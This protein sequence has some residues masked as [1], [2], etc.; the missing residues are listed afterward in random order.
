MPKAV[1]NIELTNLPSVIDDL[2][3]YDGAFFLLRYHGKP[4]GKIILP[5]KN[6]RIVLAD[7]LEKIKAAVRKD[8]KKAVV[9]HFLFSDTEEKFQKNPR[10]TIAI[11]TRDR[12]DDLKDCLDALM[13]LPE[14]GQEII[15][16]DNAPSTNDTKDLVAQYPSVRYVLEEK[17]G[18]DIA[19]NR[20]IAEASNDIVAFTDDDALVDVNWLDAIV[21]HFKDPIVMCVTGMTM[22]LEMETEAQEAFENYNPFGKGFSKKTFSTSKNDPLNVGNIGAG[23]NMALRK[24]YIT[25]TGWFDEALDAGTITQA[26]GDHEF[27]ARILL[28]GYHIVYDPEAL[29]W[30]RHRRTWKEA[31]KAMHGY[32]VGVYAFWTKLLFA[33]KQY[34]ILRFPRIWLINHQ[35]PNL[36]KWVFKRNRNYPLSFILVE[37]QGCIKGPFAY[38]KSRKQLNEN[39]KKQ[40]G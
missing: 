38:F 11:C 32:G 13:Q 15:V 30:H 25:E 14:R 9:N 40:N 37:L 7:H 8:W 22:P 12:T 26:G 33:E 19:R 36:Y 24:T 1:K 21:Q 10:A 27:F 23:A 3:S 6:G 20:A 5:A 28:A 17:K 29:S 34:S 31:T 16:V 4:V 35:L 18:L 39:F 2:H